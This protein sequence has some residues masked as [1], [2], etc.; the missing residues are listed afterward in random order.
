MI[1]VCSMCNV[2]DSSFVHNLKDRNFSLCSLL[3]SGLLTS[4]LQDSSMLSWNLP[5]GS[6]LLCYLQDSNFLRWNLGDRNC[7]HAISKMAVWCRGIFKIAVL[8]C[9]ICNM[10]ISYRTIY[11]LKTA[12]RAICKIGKYYYAICSIAVPII[13]RTATLQEKCL[14]T[15]FF[16]VRIFP[17]SD[18]YLSVFS[19]NAG[20]YG[21]SDREVWRGLQK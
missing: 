11:K 1:A 7:V 21:A 8:D 18:K 14:N 17:H 6:F 3:G 2:H 12:Y 20:K 10:V 5:G 9:S 15:E 16:L 13:S 19:P 4:N